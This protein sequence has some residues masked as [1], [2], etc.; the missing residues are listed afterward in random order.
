MTLREA[1]LNLAAN[2]AVLDGRC[3]HA[4]IEPVDLLLTGETVAAICAD[5]LIELPPGWL[6]RADN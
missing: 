4:A 2:M 5:C 1:S 3:S 6:G